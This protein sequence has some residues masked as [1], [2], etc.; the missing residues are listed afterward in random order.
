MLENISTFLGIYFTNMVEDSMEIFMDYFSVIVN[1][2]ESCLVPLG[3]FLKRCIETNIVL[4][5]EKVHF[6][7]R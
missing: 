7:V 6:I 2:F 5:W 1:T 4:N 3:K